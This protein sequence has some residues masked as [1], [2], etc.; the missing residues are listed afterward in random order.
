VSKTDLTTCYKQASYI[1]R[2][3]GKRRSNAEREAGWQNPSTFRLRST[4][5]SDSYPENILADGLQ[6]LHS[7]QVHITCFLLAL[8]AGLNR[9]HSGGN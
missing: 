4:R 7:N 6:E 3:G 5:T 1:Q 8:Y 9:G 2:M